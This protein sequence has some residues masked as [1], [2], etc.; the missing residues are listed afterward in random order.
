MQK[1]LGDD[2]TW[3]NG[4]I[5]L[6]SA[7]SK[8]VGED[9]EFLPARL[10]PEPYAG[11]G[12]EFLLASCKFPLE[13]EARSDAADPSTEEKASN[14]QRMIVFAQNHRDFRRARDTR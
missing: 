11:A 9:V 8:T 7:L 5:A 1:K 4:S 2:L 6:E 13:P 12:R 3:D 10:E 14:Y